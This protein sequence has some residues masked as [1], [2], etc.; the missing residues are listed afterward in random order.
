MS[1]WGGLRVRAQSRGV[2][3]THVRRVHLGIALACRFC[4][5]KVWWQA[6]YWL[7]HMRDTHS[8]MPLYEPIS[9]SSANPAVSSE[10]AITE[11]HFEIPAPSKKAKLDAT[12][13]VK[14]EPLE[15]EASWSVI[16]R[17]SYDIYVPADP[18]PE[19]WMQ[20]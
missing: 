6:H 10:I 5:N 14:T 19:R 18:P 8:E 11:E 4:P 2:V 20:P 1:L 15:V 16:S 12:P 3:C 13:P 9:M 17:K 7:L